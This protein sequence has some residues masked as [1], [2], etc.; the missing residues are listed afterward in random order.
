MLK[1]LFNWVHH[2]RWSALITVILGYSPF[3]AISFNLGVDIVKCLNIT[4]VKSTLTR[5]QFFSSRVLSLLASVCPC[6]RVSICPSVRQSEFVRAIAHH[7][8]RI[9]SLNLDNQYKKPLRCFLF[10]GTIDLELQGQ[11][12]ITSPNLPHFEL[13][14]IITHC[15]FKLGSPNV[16]YMCNIHRLKSLSLW[17]ATIKVKFN[18][19]FQHLRFYHY[20]IYINIT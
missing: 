18:F 11:I 15:P 16:D 3:I 7:A 14:C 4:D 13:V 2:L 9:G 12:N 10:R 6:A 19:K 5:C 20:M 17:G 1:P 8:F